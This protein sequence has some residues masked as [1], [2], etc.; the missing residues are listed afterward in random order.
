MENEADEECEPEKVLNMLSKE[1]LG[2]D[3]QC[4]LINGTL[5][6]WAR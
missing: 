6:L 4:L 1:S 2:P 5:P 3:S